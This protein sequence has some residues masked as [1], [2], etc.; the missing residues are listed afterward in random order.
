[1]TRP[2]QSP[3]NSNLQIAR[4]LL[5]SAL[6]NTLV[7]FDSALKT[8]S[9]PTES[10][11][12]E[13]APTET[14]TPAQFELLL[15]VLDAHLPAPQRSAVQ[16]ALAISP[17][18]GGNASPRLQSYSEVVRAR[19]LAQAQL[20]ELTEN[21]PKNTPK[22]AR[23]SL[24]VLEYQSGED[25]E[26]VAVFEDAEEAE[27]YAQLLRASLYQ[28]TSFAGTENL[29]PSRARVCVYSVPYVSTFARV[30][31]NATLEEMCEELLTLCEEVT[32]LRETSGSRHEHFSWDAILQ[33]LDWVVFSAECAGYATNWHTQ[34]AQYMGRPVSFY[35]ATKLILERLQEAMFIL[36]GYDWVL[37]SDHS[38]LCAP[39]MIQ[40][41]VDNARGFLARWRFEEAADDSRLEEVHKAA[42]TYEQTKQESEDR[43]VAWVDSLT[44]PEL[45]ELDP[46]EVDYCPCEED[47]SEE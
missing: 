41:I 3:L 2:T 42:D 12:T 17:L 27:K 33:R 11:P 4:D 8:E 22:S 34:C 46:A 13:S 38:V 45:E 24:V 39:L 7:A 26:T 25:N 9:A 20:H 36:W 35:S 44:A 21:T 6:A 19:D 15:S 14:L 43:F 23:L 10:A 28:R 29:R 16:E 30:K 32:T 47:E 31:K 5:V 18:C 40:A 1:M 37:P